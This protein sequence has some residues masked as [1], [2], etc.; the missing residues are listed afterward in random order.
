[1]GPILSKISVLSDTVVATA[2]IT[3]NQFVGFDGAPAGAGAAVLGVAMT[4]AAA[5]DALAI[6]IIV[7]R[8][9]IAGGAIPAGSAVQS[10]ANG[11]P[12]VKA[13]GAQAGIALTAA[14]N[15]GDV[16]KILVK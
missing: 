16:V 10:D 8:D 7:I 13:A 3:A 9:L 6:D 15:A 4:D 5:G 2:G 11:A 14:A 12:I 1:M